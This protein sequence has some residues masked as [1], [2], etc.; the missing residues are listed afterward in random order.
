MNS[1]T[2]L[3]TDVPFIKQH[4]SA[5]KHELLGIAFRDSNMNHD[6]GIAQNSNGTLAFYAPC[7]I[8]ANGFTWYNGGA[9]QAIMTLNNSGNLDCYGDVSGFNT[10]ISDSNYKS[11]VQPYHDWINVVQGL[12]PVSFVWNE[13]T[14]LTNK[15]GTNDIGLL[16]QEVAD[17][18]PLAHMSKEC[19]GKDVQ[20]VRYEKLITVLLAAIKSHEERIQELEDKINTN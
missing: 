19:N 16:A 11:N 4:P 20:M 8:E 9:S 12:T 10:S 18:F 5:I 15:I 17:V 6:A 14:P 13:E 2:D 7:N 3:I 1:F